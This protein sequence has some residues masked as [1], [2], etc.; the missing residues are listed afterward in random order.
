MR[1]KIEW[2]LEEIENTGSMQIMRV[3]VR[4]GWLITTVVQDARLK[5]LSSSSVILPDPDHEW[6]IVKSIREPEVV[7]K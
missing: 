7:Q 5:V 4:G 6:Q 2:K 1:K 3:Q